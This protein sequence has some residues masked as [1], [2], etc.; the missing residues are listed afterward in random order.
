MEQHRLEVLVEADQPI[1]HLAESI[2]NQGILNARRIRQPDNTFALVPEVSGDAMR[3]GLRQAAAEVT[4]HATADRTGGVAKHDLTEAALRL[5][6]AGGMVTGNGDAA[7]VKMGEYR[8]MV[9]LLPHLGLLG[10]CAQ[11]RTIPGRMN[12][13]PATLVCAEAARF[14]PEWMPTWLVENGHGSPHTQSCRESIEEVQRVRMDPMLNPAR[15]AL[16]SP[17]EANR[18]ERRLEASERA[19]ETGDAAAALATKS[20]MMP[21]RY[22]RIAQGAIFSWA[23]DA[24]LTS[25]L[26]VDTFYTM[27]CVFASDMVV[28]GGRAT[29]HGRLRVLAVR[30]AIVTRDV[31]SATRPEA[32]GLAEIRPK[33]GQ[34]FSDHVTSRAEQ[35]RAFLKVV[36]A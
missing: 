32:V 34:V 35:V 21:R 15:R 23:V 18:M 20:R 29:G 25:E 14:L 17:E 28:G 7:S 36:D 24:T 31:T 3:N 8:K 6:F 5:L 26:D 33:V 11:N 1:K 22:E 12:V 27:F 10:G 13:S 30:R 19:S 16:L 4:L 9:D 2:G